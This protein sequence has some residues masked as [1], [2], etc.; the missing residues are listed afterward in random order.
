MNRRSLVALAACAFVTVSA[1][2]VERPVKSATLAVDATRL[3]VVNED[4]GSLTI[5]DT[6]TRSKVAE[7]AVCTTP[8]TVALDGDVAFVPCAD[9]RIA[10]VELESMR[11]DV[12][13]A[14]VEPFGVIADGSRLFVTD[15][16]ASSVR[17]LDTSL[18]LLATIATDEYPRGLAFDPAARRLYVTHFRSGNVS[19]IDVDAL[20]VVAVWT[21][22]TDANLSQSIAL[23]RGCAYLPQTRSNASNRALL[24]D[25]TVFPVVN[26]VDLET[27]APLTRER[28]ALDII[29]QP[30]NMPFDATITADGS[31]LYVI[32][33]GSDDLS[34]ITLEF[35]EVVAHLD[36]GTNPRGVVLSP[37]ERFVYVN[38][39]LAGTVSVIDTA[40]DTVV[41][42]I[43][44]TTIPLHP[45]VLRGKILFNS[46]AAASLSK[47]AWISCATCHFEGGADGRTWFFRDGIRNTPA[48]FGV[49]STL[50]MHWSGDLD[51]LQDVENT[52]RTV[53]S[54]A[55]LITGPVHCSPACDETRLNAGRSRELDDLAL[56]MSTLRA[57]R[58]LVVG[59]S[60]GAALFAMHC[61]E[62]H[63]AP[64]YTDRAK[65][66]VGTGG[67]F[68]RKGNAFDTPSLRGAFDSAPYLHDGSAATIPEAIRRHVNVPADAVDEIA[69]FVQ[70][71]PSPRA[72][73]RAV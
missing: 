61:A 29:D 17:V 28:I 27:G 15:H 45:N 41:D 34:A 40:T 68:E 63:P 10:R 25:N 39:A 5:I 64:L 18:G 19:V 12:A 53:Q 44:A 36:L 65:H 52:I 21:A 22:G 66:D 46:S 9:G 49:A 69:A 62:C 26:V 42:T 24:F 31:K 43:R 67:V 47:D 72:K 60:R 2:T 4:S 55:G 38:N 51:E 11:V 58:R 30:V 20:R 8:R 73:R 70:S 50:P 71:L 33:A 7:I 23:A 13:E 32:H 14:G 37:D 56:F 6:P 57:P 3:V 59:T 48:L 1:T 16:G 54:G 35:Q